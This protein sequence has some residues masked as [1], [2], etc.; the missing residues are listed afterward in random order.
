MKSMDAAI[1]ET[2]HRKKQQFAYILNHTTR[3]NLCSLC[4]CP[5]DAT[6]TRKLFEVPLGYR[7]D[8]LCLAA[9]RFLPRICLPCFSTHGH[10][11]VVMARVITKRLQH[12]NVIDQRIDRGTSPDRQIALLELLAHYVVHNF[13]IGP[14][15]RDITSRTYSMQSAAEFWKPSAIYRHL[16][17]R[18]GV[19]GRVCQ[20]ILERYPET[21]FSYSPL[22]GAGRYNAIEK[23]IAAAGDWDIARMR[24]DYVWERNVV[25][26]VTGLY[27]RRHRTSDSL[28]SF[29]MPIRTRLRYHQ[30]WVRYDRAY[31]RVCRAVLHGIEEAAAVDPVDNNC[32]EYLG[33]LVPDSIRIATGIPESW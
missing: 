6:P 26:M 17:K 11:R 32:V 30:M 1:L 3:S 5:I 16:R 15:N 2:L 9:M 27:W 20:L 25:D 18:F 8:E 24:Y 22:F 10:E 19:K 13:G 4:E 29:N 7:H 14:E 12:P 28:M 21:E 31:D 33:H 23:R